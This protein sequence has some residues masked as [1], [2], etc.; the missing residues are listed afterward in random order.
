MS[1][2]AT[3]LPLSLL[4][5][6]AAGCHAD[7]DGETGSLDSGT[8]LVDADGDGYTADEDC[9]DL[10][11]MTNPGVEESCDGVDNNCDDEIDEGLNQSWYVDVDGD[12][13][14]DPSDEVSLCWRP[15][16]YV[17]TATD[18]DDADPYVYP[19]QEEI[20]DGI[21]NDCDGEIDDGATGGETERWYLDA[22]GDG[23]GDG[24]AGI[25]ACGSPE[26]YV[27][28]DS[29]CDDAVDTI[30]PDADELCN[31]IDDDCDGDTDEDAV[32]ADAWYPDVDEDGYGDEGS[33]VRACEAP[34]GYIPDGTDCDDLYG[35]TNPGADEICDDR[36][37]DCDGVVDEDAVDA[38]EWYTDSDGDGYG[39]AA[40]A[41]RACE[42]PSGSVSDATDCDD[43]EADV[44][45]GERE[46][47]NDV[48]DDC[49]GSVDESARDA[50]T[51]YADTDADGYG[52]AS[53]TTTACDA[54]AGY[55][56]D[57]TDCDDDDAASYPSASEYCD[58]R[59]NDCD[60]SVDEGA[61]DRTSYYKDADGDAYGDSASKKRSCDPIS[62]Y[63]TDKTDCDD[64]DADINPAATELCNGIDDDCDGTV[65]DGV[66]DGDTYY[67]DADGDGWGTSGST[68]TACEAPAGYVLASGDCDDGDDDI[69]PGATEYCND[70]DDDCDGTVDESP[71]DGTSYYADADGDTYGDPSAKISACT[72][73]S[74][75][76]TNKRDCDDTD[77]AIKP[78]ADEY[79]NG[80]DDDCDGSVDESAVD[81][82]TWYID[83][84]G[85]DFGDA[86]TKTKACDAPSGY[87]ADK[88][89][90]DDDDDGVYPGA[91][92]YCN[93]ID[94]DCDGTVDED[95]VDETTWFRDRDGDAWGDPT[96]SSTSCD[97]PSGYVSDSGDCKDRDA[98]IHPGADEVCEDAIDQDCDGIDAPCGLSGDED[99]AGADLRLIGETTYDYAG[100]S[101]D[102]AGDVDGDGYD[103]IVIGAYG[104]DTKARYAGAAY[105]VLGPVSGTKDLSTADAKLTGEAASDK[106][107]YAVAGGGDVDGDGYADVLVGAIGEGTGGSTAGAS[108]LVL[109]PIAGTSN[110]SSADLQVTG[111]TA[112]D[113]MGFSLAGG[114][115][116][117]DDGDDD[118]LLPAYQ[119]D[120]GGA[121]S[122]AVYVFYGSSAL[123]GTK[124]ASTAD[125][126]LVG[127]KSGDFAGWSVS[128]D[129][130]VDGDGVPDIGVGAPS[131]DTGGTNA[132]AGYLV[133]GPASGTTDLSDADAIFT[134]A[135]T[136]D[137]LGS[138]VS[139][140]GDV[141]GD[142]YGDML[143][144]AYGYDLGT[145]S[146]IGIVYLFEGPLTGTIS[147]TAADYYLTGE[148][149]GDRAGYSVSSGGDVD[150]DG[151][152]D[153][154]IGAYRFDDSTSYDVGAGYL[155]LG[156][157]AGSGSLSTGAAR[158]IGENTGDYVGWDVSSG[159]DINADGFSD[160]L[161]GAWKMDDGGPDAGAGYLM[162]GGALP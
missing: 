155:F 92:E 44:N 3:S 12:G 132:G 31:S 43:D 86:D 9:N 141:D 118:L 138:G 93:D 88:T 101:V 94:D 148:V 96:S 143:V 81:R 74:G 99:L 76:V 158:L 109:G 113:N 90:C 159:G 19:G 63:V 102:C 53:S 66:D 153:L 133:L 162:Y 108:Y 65:D 126:Q 105:V 154:L 33:G 32:D 131:S 134:G 26:G 27:Q 140:A 23:Y 89:D 64:G 112:N 50:D 2:L 75:Y 36:D 48:D 45:P 78:G 38:T 17:P 156:P 146:E 22:D 137:Y 51:W 114:G 107:G 8:G 25:E 58:D 95:P 98:T 7:K 151:F 72:K 130:D 62:G 135:S 83:S 106:A 54:P 157:L 18:C 79:C 160:L 100:A 147:A 80:L 84:D 29:D 119:A 16:G 87:V 21:D 41:S 5:A 152:S 57:K 144:G 34:L 116:L 30:H 68:K 104:D 6:L 24:D 121:S 14:G 123:T 145:A 1:R 124:S 125:G 129:V 35:P 73:P 55:V 117:N 128:G 37:N 71:A 103:D 4:L 110:L 70:E 52:D 46:T 127:E 97:K 149:A 10:D 61:V 115:D 142:G 111:A 47:C 69:Y 42:A 67:K 150:K 139:L 11:A 59:D 28:D 40:A 85:D 77:S 49:D 20:C 91:D 136:L 13:F 60:G 39:D 161:L 122:G 56:A 82:T 15:D 120:P